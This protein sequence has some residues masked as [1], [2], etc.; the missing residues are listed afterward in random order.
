[1]TQPFFFFFLFVYVGWFDLMFVFFAECTCIFF[2]GNNNVD[3]LF[4]FWLKSM[5]ELFTRCLCSVLLG[6]ICSTER[7]LLK[8]IVFQQYI[9]VSNSS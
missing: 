8:D 9:F 2:P 1:M 6:T 3:I 4:F 7:T 5:R